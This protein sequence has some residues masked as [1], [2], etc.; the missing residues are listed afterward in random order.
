[1][2]D[3]ITYPFPNFNGCTVEVWEWMS[4]FMPHLIGFV[5]TYHAGIKRLKLIHVS[6]RDHIKLKDNHKCS[7]NLENLSYN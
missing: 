2:L 1:M 7:C 3:E 6:K 4:N 5:S